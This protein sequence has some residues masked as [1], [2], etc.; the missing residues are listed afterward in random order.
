MEART[1][2]IVSPSAKEVLKA[3]ILSRR[4]FIVWEHWV[5]GES[6]YRLCLGEF[7]MAC[8]LCPDVD[9][10]R[11]GY[12]HAR[13]Q[14]SSG[15]AFEAILKLTDGAVGFFGDRDLRGIGCLIRRQGQRVNGPLEIDVREQQAPP[16]TQLAPERDPRPFLMQRWGMLKR[17]A[18]LAGGLAPQPTLPEGEEP[19]VLQFRKQA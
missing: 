19:R 17:S 8:V 12:V 6:R 2:E 7:D 1:L 15:E 11:K 4:P 9:R 3:R 5:A 14:R 18:G 16:G 13:L 10:R